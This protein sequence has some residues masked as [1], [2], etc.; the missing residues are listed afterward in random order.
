MYTLIGSYPSPFV[1][2]LRML[3]HNLPFT[4]K[5]LNIYEA[6]GAVELHKVNPINQIP[7]LLDGEK[8]VWDSRVIFNY[9]NLHHKLENIDWED[10]NNLSAIDGALNAGVA[11]FLLRRSGVN[12]N[13]Q[14]MVVAR[15]KDRM[16]SVL[17][18]FKPYMQGEGLKNWDFLTMSIYSFLDWATFREI[19]NISDRPECIKFLEAHANRPAVVATQIPKV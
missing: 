12:I 1:R 2:R 4:F 7:V 10:E 14:F 15:Y 13:D 9:I 16:Q 5:E 3:M 11:L 19:L 18:Y 17:D 6:E 8:K